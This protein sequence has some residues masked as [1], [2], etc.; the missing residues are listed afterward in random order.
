MEAMPVIIA[1]LTSGAYCLAG[2]EPSQPS[3]S[4]GNEGLAWIEV[5]ARRNAPR[6]TISAVRSDLP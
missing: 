5:N 2:M 3:G 4:L 1:D 6:T